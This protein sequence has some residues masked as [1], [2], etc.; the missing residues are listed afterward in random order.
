METLDLYKDR[1]PYTVILEV[2]GGKKTFKIPTELTVEESERLLEAEIRISALSKEEVEEGKEAEKQLDVYF[3]LLKEYILIL[4]Q[5]YQ[6][7][8]EMADLNKMLSRAEVVKIFEFFKKQRFLKLLGL[9]GAEED[10][11]KK[12]T[13]KPENRLDALRQSITFLVVSG[14]SLLELRKLYLDEFLSYYNSL[15]YIKEKKGEIKEGTY[16]TL[17]AKGDGDVFSLKKQ[18]FSIQKNGK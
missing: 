1:K 17:K 8:L 18:L 2:K 15:V 6:T 5:H 9:D 16:Q 3:A 7:K 14:F 13:E 4:L 12:K 10:D 11:V